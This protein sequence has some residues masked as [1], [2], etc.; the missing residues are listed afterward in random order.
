MM[1]STLHSLKSTGLTKMPGEFPHDS[2]SEPVGI[3]D[4]NIFLL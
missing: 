4:P 2:L 1:Q 3:P